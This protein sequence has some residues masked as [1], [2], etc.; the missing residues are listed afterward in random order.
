MNTSKCSRM[1]IICATNRNSKIYDLCTLPD[2]TYFETQLYKHYSRYLKD[3]LFDR[4]LPLL[5][6]KNN[7]DMLTEIVHIWRNF[8][9][10]FVKFCSKL[11]SYL[12]RYTSN[13]NNRIDFMSLQQ[14][15]TR[16]AVKVTGCSKRM[17][18]TTLKF[19]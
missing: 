12:V 18:L 5:K 17:F 6:D 9:D 14:A 8:R 3:F 11:F 4:V 10:V 15:R 19:N 1:N 13:I 2:C 7:E 16:Y